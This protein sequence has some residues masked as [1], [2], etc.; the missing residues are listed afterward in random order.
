MDDM[1]FFHEGTLRICGS[2]DID[3][4]LQD[5]YAFLKQFMPVNGI[6]MSIYESE[7]SAVRIIAFMNDLG[8]R[9]PEPIIPISAEACRL[10]ES[11]ADGVEIVNH[12]RA[13]PASR[14]VSMA[15]GLTEMSSL[16]LH[17]K[18]REEMIGVVGVFVG[19]NNRYQESHGR[20]LELLHDPCAIAMS[21]TLRYQEVLRLKEILRDDNRY[22]HRELH[23]ISGDEIIGANFGLREVMEMVRQ[24]A[25]LESLVLLLGETG[26]GKEVISS[27]LHYSS[28][29]R[30]GP[31]IKVNCGAIPENLLDSE[32]FGHEKGAFTGAIAR[33]RGLFE[34]ADNGTLFLDEIGELPPSAQVRLLRVLQTREIERVGG[35]K[36]VAVDVRVIA[37]THRNLE[38]MVRNGDFREDLWFR[39]NV[40]PITIPPLRYRKADIPALVS[41]F[42]ERKIREMKL[43]FRP[44]LSPGA[45]ERLRHYDW[46]GN[47]RELENAVERELIRSQVN[48]PDVSLAFRDVDIPDTSPE[49]SGISEGKKTASLADVNRRHIRSALEMTGGKVQ[50]E[51]GAAA[52]L[53]VHPSTLRHR[54]RKL[55]IP[56]GRKR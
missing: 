41:H 4:V 52:L 54:M 27:T 44:T 37:A 2:L 50:G 53:G 25:P 42:I 49:P 21:N 18:V 39:L 11:G 1:T 30:D 16:I 38:A 17:L 47:V 29:R 55:G 28:S 40:F 7:I 56:F 15:L 48:G 10:I 32:L 14:D 20:L 45:L 35:T 13:T 12:A 23:R 9:Y 33:R 36:P 5:C 3:E 34:R 43:R 24:V 51:D 26:V 31:F 6:L 46:P 22:L 8:I 19:E